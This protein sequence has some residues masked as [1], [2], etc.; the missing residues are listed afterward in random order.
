MTTKAKKKTV[1]KK[2]QV[3]V[4]SVPVIVRKPLKTKQ[5]FIEFFEAIPEKKW[6]KGQLS[7]NKGR[8]CA[9]GHLNDLFKDDTADGWDKTLTNFNKLYKTKAG[10]YATLVNL[11]DNHANEV[12]SKFFKINT[13]KKRVLA[14]LKD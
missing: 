12:A 11:N 8:H 10:A 2:A 7:D 1:K 9:M 4:K 14:F 6:C 5:D 3:K 13:P